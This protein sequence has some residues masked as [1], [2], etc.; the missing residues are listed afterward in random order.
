[1]LL[2]V[3]GVLIW[4]GFLRSPEEEEELVATATA[5]VQAGAEAAAPT[6]APTMA[7]P[8]STPAPTF[9]PIPA[10]TVPP[11]PTPAVARMVAGVD[12]VNVRTGPGTNFT[13]LGYIDPDGEAPVIGQYGD[14]WQ[15]EYQGSPAWVYGEI[16]TVYDVDAIAEVQP[17]PSPT[18]P[19]PT[20]T[21]PPTA[22]PTPAAPTA[23]PGP[24]AEFRGL[25]PNAYWVEGAPGP[26]GKGEKI[27]F[28]M[29]VE[30]A[31]GNTIP[32][33]ALGT[34]VQETG[35]F[36]ES[37]TNREFTPFKHAP[38]NPWRDHIKINSS[39]TYHLW[40]RICF[41]DGQCVN[42]MGPVQVEVN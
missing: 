28:N 30:N 32:F 9:T 33:N 15:I 12:G 18:F 34:W 31:T 29:D 16:V 1:L 14:W 6:V 7:L 4:Y 10:T 26:F 20:A 8:T 42:L 22:T 27:W 37:W 25:V 23:T 17:P 19:P 40:M 21:S 24:P 11:S 3:G 2:I 38:F 41:A 35:Q 5:T 39:G 36:Q 13:R